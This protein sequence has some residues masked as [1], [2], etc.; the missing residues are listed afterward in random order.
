MTDKEM[1]SL[2]KDELA[3]YE[4]IFKTGLLNGNS[5]LSSARGSMRN[6]V[7]AMVPGLESAFNSLAAIGISTGQVGSD[8]EETRTGLLRVVDEE[9]LMKALR[10][11][12][13]KASDLFGRDSATENSKGIARQLRDMLNGYTR[14]DGILTRKVGRSGVQASNSQLDLQMKVINDQIARHEVR[15]KS[16]EESLIRQFANLETLLS[17]YQTQSQAFSQQL[18][19]LA[20]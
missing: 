7:S 20:G 3:A 18:A 16:R 2:P 17:Q 11:N 12:P 15:M 1:S 6:I 8:Y 4:G 10:E 13:Q 14:S 9:K 19:Q 5:V